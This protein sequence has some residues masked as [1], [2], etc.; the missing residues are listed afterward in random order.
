MRPTT[1]TVWR[2]TVQA[3]LIR[4]GR[5]G[6]PNFPL[7]NPL[8]S[9]P[10]GDTDIFV[11]KWNAAGSGILYSTYIGGS[12]RDV[13]LRHRSGYGGQR[14][15]RGL[16]ILGEFP[17]YQRRP[18][19]IIFSGQSKAFVLKLNPSGNSLIYS[20]FLGGS[21]SDYATGIAVDATGQAYIS[22]YTA[23]VDFPVSS[24]A[25]QGSYGGGEFD[26]FF[27]KLNAAG[28]Q[29]VYATYLGGIGND[30]AF[31][32]ALDTAA[33]CLLDRDKRNRRIFRCFRLFRPHIAKATPS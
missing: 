30:T 33:K 4:S 10:A 6:R 20:T 12:N 17:H 16:Y 27:A 5:L 9:V 7:L 25:F 14:L 15:H 32:V 24:N 13:P 31:A 11:T 3:A 23:S 18:K 26:G 28:S 22:G 19:R 21:G 29:L 1:A 8:Q 2:W